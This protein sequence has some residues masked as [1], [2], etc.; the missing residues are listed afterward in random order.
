[1]AT[2]DGDIAHKHVKHYCVK[3]VCVGIRDTLVYKD[4]SRIRKD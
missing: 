2:C 4:G 3:N 1:M